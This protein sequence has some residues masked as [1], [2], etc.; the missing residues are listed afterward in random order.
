MLHE[1]FYRTAINQNMIYSGFVSAAN[2]IL[3]I[4]IKVWIIIKQI[5]PNLKKT[6]RFLRAN[7]LAPKL[8]AKIH[9]RKKTVKKS[10]KAFKAAA[11]VTKEMDG[12][13]KRNC[14]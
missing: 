11:G 7:L 6:A 8:A 2:L 1:I 5:N 13:T 14:S 3:R 12:D 9:L 4:R 10:G